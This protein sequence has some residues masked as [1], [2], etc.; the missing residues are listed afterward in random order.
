LS[1]R[2]IAMLSYAKKIAV[3][4]ASVTQA[5]IEELRI[6]GFS[7][8]EIYDIALCAAIRCFLSRFYDAIGASPDTAFRDMEASFRDPLVVGKPLDRAVSA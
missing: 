3:N 1:K 8:A 5:D 4:A 7:D 2:D 6:C